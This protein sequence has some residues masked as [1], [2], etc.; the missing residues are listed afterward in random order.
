MKERKGGEC[1]CQNR[2]RRKSRGFPLIRRRNMQVARI[3][4]EMKDGNRVRAVARGTRR[5]A[6]E[7]HKEDQEDEDAGGL[8]RREARERRGARR[9]QG[10][11]RGRWR[12]GERRIQRCHC[13]TK[14]LSAAAICAI[15][16]SD[17][18]FSRA[19]PLP[20]CARPLMAAALVSLREAG[21]PPRASSRPASLLGQ[22]VREFRHR[23]SAA[24]RIGN[25]CVPPPLPTSLTPS[26]GLS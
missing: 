8:I 11:R 18:L 5:K 21:S 2:K 1:G 16:A 6:K 25:S 13:W 3:R 22:P 26:R 7:D 23:F 12:D 10:N 19:G 14:A 20:R 15:A 17:L 9:T 4:G 24:L